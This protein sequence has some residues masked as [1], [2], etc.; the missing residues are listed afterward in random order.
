MYHAHAGFELVFMAAHSLIS[1]FLAEHPKAATFVFRV[2]HHIPILD[3]YVPIAPHISP[4]FERRARPASPPKV[5][6]LE[7]ML[8]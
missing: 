2:A 1:R 7:R 8:T 5:Q 6:G 4:D 3:H